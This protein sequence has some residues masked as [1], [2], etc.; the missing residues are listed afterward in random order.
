MSVEVGPTHR[1]E[2]NIPNA[3]TINRI[4]GRTGS[5][6]Q[7]HAAQVGYEHFRTSCRTWHHHHRGLQLHGD[8]KTRVRDGVLRTTV[9]I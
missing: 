6:G 4:A 8:A 2:R 3:Y 9:R 1:H 7:A 5:V